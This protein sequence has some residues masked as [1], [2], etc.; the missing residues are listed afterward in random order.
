MALV[1]IALGSNLGDRRKNIN[2]ALERVA[3]I[4][5][6]K[7]LRVSPLYKTAPVGMPDDAPFFLNGAAEIETQCPP[8]AL[9][10]QLLQIEEALGRTRSHLIHYESRTV[11]LD[12]LLYGDEIIHESRLRVP[13]PRMLKRE[14]VL[15]PL[16]DLC[17][18]K[19]IP[20]VELT[21]EE[22]LMVLTSGVSETCVRI[23][24]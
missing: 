20:S 11:D 17:P 8:K 15:R 16:A 14:F 18:E 6:T 9:I 1:Y 12:I 13:H 10:E 2:R 3:L 21:V 22:A 4:D 24:P 5:E 19:K 7:V 23:V